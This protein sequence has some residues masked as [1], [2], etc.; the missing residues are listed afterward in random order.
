MNLWISFF[1]SRASILRKLNDADRV[2]LNHLV[3]RDELTDLEIAR[4]AEKH[5]GPDALGK[6]LAAKIMVITRH[7]RSAEY[8]RWL[9]RWENQDADL[10]KAVE[11][12][13]QRFEFL[14]HLIQ[15]GPVEGMET[16]SK[17]LQAR[18]L[19]LA[20]EATD[21]ELVE[22]AAKN[23]WIKN[24]IRVVQEQGKLEIQKAGEKAAEIIGDTTI[25]RAEQQKRIRKIFE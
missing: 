25:D 13:K 22:G 2:A 24:L 7:R 5:I 3:R 21:E 20:A 23:G 15:T 18:L 8:K 19:T 17:S 6:T 11:T 14:S 9:D 12:Q 1:M 4:E 16:V 10:R